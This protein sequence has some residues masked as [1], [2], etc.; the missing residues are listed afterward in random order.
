MPKCYQGL[1]VT[2]RLRVQFWGYLSIEPG[3]IYFY[4]QIGIF[5]NSGKKR[6]ILDL[7][8]DLISDPG[9]KEKRPFISFSNLTEL[10]DH[11]KTHF[12]KKLINH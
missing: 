8:W 1:S 3:E 7:E 4:L 9:D 5:F 10:T 12:I 6:D 11:L 2:V